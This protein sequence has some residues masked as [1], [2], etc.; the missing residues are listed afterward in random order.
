[1]PFILINGD[2][3]VYGHNNEIAARTLSA[4]N[5]VHSIQMALVENEQHSSHRRRRRQQQQQQHIMP[6]SGEIADGGASP[7]NGFQPNNTS[8]A[9]ERNHRID[10]EY[11]NGAKDDAVIENRDDSENSERHAAINKNGE[12]ILSRRRRYLIFPPGSSVQIGMI[13]ISS[14]IICF[15]SFLRVAGLTAYTQLRN[16]P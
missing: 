8:S 16:E 2:I 12:K 10:N 5:L 9:T 11:R 15:V 3:G 14:A 6:E 7:V 1:M 4:P 13:L